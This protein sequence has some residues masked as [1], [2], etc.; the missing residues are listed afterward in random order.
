VKLKNRYGTGAVKGGQV[1]VREL[2]PVE[3]K[4]AKNP[5]WADVIA[6]NRYHLKNLEHSAIRDDQIPCP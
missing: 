4:T 2:A 1:R 5:G 6:Q 3:L